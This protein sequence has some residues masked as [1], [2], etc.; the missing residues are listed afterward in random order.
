MLEGETTPELRGA[1]KFTIEGETDRGVIG[2]QGSFKVDT[3]VVFCTDR[4]N[5]VFAQAKGAGISL[6]STLH[7]TG[8]TVRVKKRI[9]L[10]H[11]GAS[12]PRC[13][14]QACCRA[15]CTP[16]TELRACKVAV[17]VLVL[18]CEALVCAARAAGVQPAVTRAAHRGP[19]LWRCR[20]AAA[21]AAAR[22]R[23]P[24]AELRCRPAQARTCALRGSMISMAAA[25][26]RT[27]VAEFRYRPAQARTCALRV[28]KNFHGRVIFVALPWGQPGHPCRRSRL[29]SLRMAVSDKV[30]ASA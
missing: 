20:P 8:A 4:S 1:S 25:R 27:P 9:S 7:T 16:C 3:Q 14:C 15:R 12:Q 30:D 26:P 24:V 5:E 21:D 11:F 29:C 10:V 19:G 22:A 13:W 18:M 17:N 23:A 6:S 28:R 2:R